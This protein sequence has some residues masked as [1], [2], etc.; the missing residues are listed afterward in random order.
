MHHRRCLEEEGSKLF[1]TVDQLL[2]FHTFTSCFWG[3]SKTE[4]RCEIDIL[5]S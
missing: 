3:N 2:S 1:D 5:S 4:G